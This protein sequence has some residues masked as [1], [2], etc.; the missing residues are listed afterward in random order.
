MA[1]LAELIKAERSAA[2]L[3]YYFGSSD[4]HKKYEAAQAAT[5]AAVAALQQQLDAMTV[6]WAVRITVPRLHWEE[7]L[8]SREECERFIANQPLWYTHQVG[9]EFSIVKRTPAG[10]WTPAQDTDQTKG[11]A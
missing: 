6:E 11:E 3:A 5:D 7:R 4:L 9:E 1:E 10:P 2:D 8:R